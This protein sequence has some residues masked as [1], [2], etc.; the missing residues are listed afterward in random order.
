LRAGGQP[1]L[2]H[3]ST[4]DKVKLP[5]PTFSTVFNFRDLGGHLTTDG[6]VVQNGRLY[7]SDSLHRVSVEEGRQLA[8]LGVRT[9][10]DLR[11]PYEIERDGRVPAELGLAYHNIHPVHREWNPALYDETAGPHRYLADRYLDMAEEGRAGLGAALRLIA[12]PEHAPI[13]MHCFAGKDRTGVLAALTLAL[14]GVA[15]PDIATEYALSEAAQA[16]LS[17]RI[18]EET[19]WPI[20]DVPM[21]FVVCPP[22]A[23][24]LFLA[25][26]R[27]RYGSVAGYA[28][29]AGVGAEYVAAL[30]AHLLR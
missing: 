27:E 3:A 25:G 19:T 14:L 11:R 10:L 23:M 6:R 26:L 13:V 18:R 8:E 22:Q 2:N 9:V 15:E 30:R 12:G 4:L 28:A 1:A 16:P 21:H 20:N 17:R 7:R 5:S 24:L 29:D